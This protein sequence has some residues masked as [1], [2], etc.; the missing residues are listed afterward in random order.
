[1]LGDEGVGQI[2]H[3][4]MEPQQAVDGPVVD[5]QALGRASRRVAVLVDEP[6]SAG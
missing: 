5:A 3:I 4:G 1:M 6:R 2:D